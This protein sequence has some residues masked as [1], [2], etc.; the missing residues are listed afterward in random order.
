MLTSKLFSNSS[1][2][3]L[4]KDVVSL[5]LS[6]SIFQIQKKYQ[7]MKDTVNPNSADGKI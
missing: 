2:V 6:F 3:R 5:K 7:N 1:S 4:M